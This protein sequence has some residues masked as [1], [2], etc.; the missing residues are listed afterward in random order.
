MHIMMLH[1][2]ALH[3]AMFTL[4][5]RQFQWPC[6]LNVCSVV[7]TDKLPLL[8]GSEPLLCMLRV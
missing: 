1:A 3:T 4:A 5:I 7:V 2:E 8:D 6:K